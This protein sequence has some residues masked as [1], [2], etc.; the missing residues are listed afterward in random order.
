[1]C[2]WCTA[3]TLVHV[4]FPEWRFLLFWL[5][6]WFTVHHQFLFGIPEKQLVISKIWQIPCVIMDNYFYIWIY[7]NIRGIQILNFSTKSAALPYEFPFLY[8]DPRSKIHKC[9]CSCNMAKHGNLSICRLRSN[10]EH[11]LA[12]WIGHD[13][14]GQRWWSSGKIIM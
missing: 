2:I 8:R 7:G 5:A 10:I 11:S 13:S 9:K 6:Y 1:M 12:T 14:I 3:L 4:L